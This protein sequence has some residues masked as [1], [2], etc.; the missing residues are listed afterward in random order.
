MRQYQRN[1][2][3]IG[4]LIPKDQ[5]AYTIYPNAPTDLDEGEVFKYER[6]IEIPRTQRVVVIDE[7]TIGFIVEKPDQLP[8]ARISFPD[9]GRY[10]YN[11][12][13]LDEYMTKVLTDGEQIFVRYMFEGEEIGSQV[14]ERKQ[15]RFHRL[16]LFKVRALIWLMVG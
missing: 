7:N 16:L 3:S 5:I 12:A 1:R 11:K 13:E 4:D 6:G 10:V 9:A 8:V 14:I 15:A 2:Q